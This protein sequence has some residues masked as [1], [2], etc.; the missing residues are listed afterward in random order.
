MTK[1]MTPPAVTA[2]RADRL[3]DH[4]A[5]RLKAL[6][7]ARLFG[8]PGGGSSL[9]LIAAAERQ[10]IGFV[11]CRTETGAALMAAVG[12]ELSGAPG[13]VLTGI[14]PSA[15]SAV[16]GVAYASLER[17]PLILVTDAS[18]SAAPKPPH[19][20]FDQQA[21]FAPVTKGT[22]RLTPDSAGAELDRL[23]HLTR[24]DPQGPVHLD[25]SV[26]HAR[27]PV[28]A[29]VAHGAAPFEAAPP[30]AMAEARAIEDLAAWLAGAR[31]PVLV[32]GL[33]ARRAGVP[34]ALGDLAARLGCPVLVSYK[35]KGVLPETDPRFAGVF[36]GAAAEGAVLAR[37]DA[38]LMLGLDPVEMIPA[39]WSYPAP[40]GVVMRGVSEEFPFAPAHALDGDLAA[41]VAALAKRAAATDWSLA[42]IADLRAGLRE[43]L[44][45]KGAGHT[46]ESL[47]DALAQAARSG[48]RLAVDAGAH[49]FS[50]MARWPAL[51]PHGVLKSN[52][53]ST[54]G[55]AVPAAIASALHE[56]ERPAIALSGDGGL[57]MCL[58]E[59]STAARLGLPILVVVVNDAALSLIDIKQQ[60]LQ[61]PARGVRTPAVDF[62]AAARGLGCTAWRVGPEDSFEDAL[63]QALDARGPCLIDVTANPDGYGEQLAA[64]RG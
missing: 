55:F 22:L 11:L 35:A 44:A 16:N 28:A 52:G 63:R 2:Q 64:L 27:A 61:F 56:P 33:Q 58:A 40:V 9:D 60:R 32:A 48:T 38:I 17:A 59:L 31:R 45:L 49:M 62:A 20:V 34:A 8:V 15:A 1:P 51:E 5:G 13:V 7:V 50:A 19:Q 18:E 6:G 4:L 54:M 29:E 26:G 21:L 23:L 14:G 47:V 10:G 57:L 3:A 36:T 41:N 39:R 12:A 25:L 37:A 24:I 30:L 53:L 46:A 42:E 43:R